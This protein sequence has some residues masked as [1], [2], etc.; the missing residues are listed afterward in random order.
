MILLAPAALW[1]LVALP[2]I[3]IL[4]LIQ[5]RYR[6]QVVASLMLWKR[7][8]RDLEAEAS[9]RRP[10]W[11]LLLALQLLAAL[12]VGLALARPAILGGGSQRLVMVLDA[13][14]SM[15][16]RDVQPTRFA[17]AKEELANEVNKAPVDARVSLVVASQQPRVVVENGSP[18]N[19]LGA[20]EGL[21]PDT[22]AADLPA[23]IRV[24][25]GLAAPA[26]ANG[27]QV[28]VITDGATDLNLPQQSVPVS[29]KLVGGGSD[30]VAISEVTLRRAID[31]NDYLAGFA[32]VVNFGNDP[33]ST[34]MVVL[35]DNL[36]VDRS[37]VDV[38]AVGHADATFHV[39]ANA[40]T[41]SV[42]LTDRD[43]LPAGDRVDVQGYARWARTATIV[44][45][46][47]TAWEHVLSVVPD[48]TTRSIKPADFQATDYG[49]NDIVLF[50]NVVPNQ[51]PQSPTVIVNP[52]DASPLLTRADTLPR[53]RSAER[54]DADDPLLQGLDI[55]P[56]SVQQLERAVT[57]NWAAASVGAEDT[58]LILHG[59]LGNQ[60]VVMFTFDPAKSNLPHLAAFPLLM[61]NAVDWLIPGREAVLHGGLGNETNIQPRALADFSASSVAAALPSTTELWPWFVAA[62]AVFFAFEWA[63]AVRRG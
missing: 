20:L 1:F 53:Q 34:A 9:W 17:A 59:R 31:R 52:P 49:P 4:Y 15:A 54:F 50:D 27:S 40:Q 58:P 51:L 33:H 3:F 12:C 13:S 19:V 2:V 30:N 36:A 16:A 39:P 48:L 11:D 23:A 63:V 26:A 22:A 62:A 47:P 55:A 60:R 8:A 18:S 41:V 6:P 14:A 35:A 32:R 43:P 61:A 24:A 37:P 57:P 44:S 56:L 5:S 25:A 45:D 38:P 29:F 28:E 10:R 7:M 46:A 42:V 21:Q